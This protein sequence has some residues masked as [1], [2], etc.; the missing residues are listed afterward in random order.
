MSGGI[1]LLRLLGRESDGVGVRTV[2]LVRLFALSIVLW[3][4]NIREVVQTGLRTLGRAG[5]VFRLAMEFIDLFL[6]T[7]ILHHISVFNTSRSLPFR[8]VQ[9]QA[10]SY[11]S[12]FLSFPSTFSSA[13]K[14][15]NRYDP[16]FFMYLN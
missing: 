4:G 14:L 5:A 15:Y 11:H 16:S 3:S 12:V 10:K 8:V 6:H 7:T 2:S 9:L 13:S 1:T